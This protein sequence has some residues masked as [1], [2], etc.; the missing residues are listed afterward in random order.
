[1]N[2]IPSTGPNTP[3]RRM[4]GGDVIAAKNSGRIVS[5]T[6]SIWMDEGRIAPTATNRGFKKMT[7][8]RCETCRFYSEPDEGVGHCRRYPPTFF[9]D[10][11]TRNPNADAYNSAFPY[12]SELDWC[13]EHQPKETKDAE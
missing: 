8:P 1:M 12:T 6:I 2:T 7:E 5:I 13:G 3:D 11:M 4:I 9:H 10:P